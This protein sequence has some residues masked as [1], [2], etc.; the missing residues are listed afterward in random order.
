MRYIIIDNNKFIYDNYYLN[1]ILSLTKGKKYS[2][3]SNIFEYRWINYPESFEKPERDLIK[4]YCQNTSI[5]LELGGNIGV[6]SCLINK[7]TD[8]K[9]EHTVTENVD[10]LVQI[11]ER[12]KLLNKA[13]FQI[14]PYNLN[15]IQSLN[16]T[17]KFYYNTLISDIEGDEYQFI[18][19]NFE[20]IS[21]HIKLMIIEFH[22]QYFCKNNGKI[23]RSLIHHC[24]DLLQSRFNTIEKI[25]NVIVY[26]SI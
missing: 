19:D 14:I 1:N 9:T 18:I 7:I 3:N 13:E 10:I 25:H 8:F 15:N 6:T 23:D 4:K 20:Y 11:L 16:H 26:R 5:V 12:H 22:Q 21:K 17:Q 2:H 24:H